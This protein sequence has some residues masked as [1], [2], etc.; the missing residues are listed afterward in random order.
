M[1]A[2]MTVLDLKK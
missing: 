2:T 1:M